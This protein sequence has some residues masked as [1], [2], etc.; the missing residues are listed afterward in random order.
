[1]EVSEKQTHIEN[2]EALK[3][4]ISISIE[5]LFGDEDFIIEKRN[6]LKNKVRLIEIEIR[7]LKYKLYSSQLTKEQTDL[8]ENVLGYFSAR[9]RKTIRLNPVAYTYLQ[10]TD[11]YSLI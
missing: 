1:M 5:T 9:C 11:K 4:A 6:E 3:K 8:H 2:L 7:E 10:N